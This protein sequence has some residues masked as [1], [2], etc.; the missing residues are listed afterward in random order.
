MSGR[1]ASFDVD[2]ATPTLVMTRVFAAPRRLVFKA[3]THPD[4][5]SAWYGPHGYT[6]TSCDIELRVAGGYRIVNRDPQGNE[7][8]YRGV[9]GEIVVPERLVSTW[10]FEAMPDKEAV[11]T[12]SFE[13]HHGRTTLTTSMVF[14]SIADR[15]A[16]LTSGGNEGTLEAMERMDALLRTQL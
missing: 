2:P 13:E 7:Y 4:Y 11:M 5:V 10:T 15:D 1:K 16:F 12:Q 14:E 6:V 9:F 8:A 3:F